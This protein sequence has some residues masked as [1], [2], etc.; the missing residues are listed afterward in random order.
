MFP[1]LLIM[2]FL[3]IFKYM[4]V[5][6]AYMEVYSVC[7]IYRGQKRVLA[8]L[9]LEVKMVLR[10]CIYTQTFARIATAFLQTLSFSPYS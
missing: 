4:S 10:H 2:Y 9:R 1:F 8:L 3:F 6:L 5:L 7:S